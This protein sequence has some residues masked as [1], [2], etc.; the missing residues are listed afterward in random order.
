MAWQQT[1]TKKG[2]T[3]AIYDTR[4]RVSRS[5]R[6]IEEETG[7]SASLDHVVGAAESELPDRKVAYLFVEAT[8]IQG[9]VQISDEHDDFAWLT[10]QQLANTQV[11]PQFKQFVRSLVNR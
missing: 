10:L 9:P 11:C 2:D 8:F 1:L 5:F 6:E 7:L 3:P 4:G